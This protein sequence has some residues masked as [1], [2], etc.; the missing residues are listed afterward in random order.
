MLERL[1]AARNRKF[2]PAYAD[3]LFSEIVYQPVEVV[4]LS[5]H[6][7]VQGH[8]AKMNL[9]ANSSSL[10]LGMTVASVPMLSAIMI[11]HSVLHHTEQLGVSSEEV[12]RGIR[13]PVLPFPDQP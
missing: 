7:F 2:L 8:S 12:F 3:R 13:L 6:P 11:M 10:L 5:D 9:S 4:T 1:L